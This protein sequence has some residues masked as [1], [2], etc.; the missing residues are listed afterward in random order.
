MKERL[1]KLFI[2]IKNK[3]KEYGIFIHKKNTEENGNTE[4][5]EEP[6]KEGL[7]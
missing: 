2:N 1:K 5:A 7:C 3:Y 6:G 4:A